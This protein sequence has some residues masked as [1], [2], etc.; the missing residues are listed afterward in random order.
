MQRYANGVL[1]RCDE[2][3]KGARDKIVMGNPFIINESL[4]NARQRTLEIL[5]G[6]LDNYEDWSSHPD[7]SRKK[8]SEWFLEHGQFSQLEIDKV[9]EDNCYPTYDYSDEYKQN[10]PGI[11]F[12][13][14]ELDLIFGEIEKK[15]LEIEKKYNFPRSDCESRKLFNLCLVEFEY[16][17]CP[18][19][20]KKVTNTPENVTGMTNELICPN[21]FGQRKGPFDYK[22]VI[23]RGF[24][25]HHGNWGSY[26]PEFVF[27]GTDYFGILHPDCT[28]SRRDDGKGLMLVTGVWFDDEEQRVVLGLECKEC[29]AKNA[30]KPFV[31]DDREIQLLNCSGAKWEK[32]QTRIDG[33]IRKGECEIIEFKSSARWDIKQKRVSRDL[34]E[35]V[36]A[37]IAGFMNGNGG[38]LLIGIDDDG[39]PL[40]LTNDYKTLGKDKILMDLR[41]F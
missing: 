6:F 39:Y 30:L 38:T 27:T 8:Y 40:G 34:E 28:N 14:I 17:E 15:D 5:I 32:V 4:D 11:D 41:T 31:C 22:G 37:T 29:G 7:A 18:D 21:C 25:P 36:C 13:K 26:S 16:Y 12:D 35:E 23:I 20:S 33:R 3:N 19:C 1:V 10:H 24:P 2:C 9:F